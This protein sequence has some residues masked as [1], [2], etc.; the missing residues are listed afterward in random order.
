MPNDYLGREYMFYQRYEDAI[1]ELTRHLSLPS[2]TWEPERCASM[3][4]IARSYVALSNLEAAQRWALKAC[5]EAPK[6]REPWVEL[7][8]IYYQQQSWPGVYYAM[9]QA[10]IITEKPMSYICEPEAWGSL[11]ADLCSIAAFNLGMIQEAI[12]LCEA[13]ISHDP[14]DPR[15]Q[16]N[17]LLIKSRLQ[18]SNSGESNESKR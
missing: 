17:L 5:A 15:L 13:A 11:P 18:L 8:K 3:R 10:L 6:E 7:G 9:K 14:V 2:S 1:K 4:Y 16:N 12:T